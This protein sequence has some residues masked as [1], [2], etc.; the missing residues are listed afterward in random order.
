MGRGRHRQTDREVKI[1]MLHL[2][3]RC[4]D[5]KTEAANEDSAVLTQSGFEHPVGFCNHR[6]YHWNPSVLP[7]K[8]IKTGRQAEKVGSIFNVTFMSIG[9]CV[10]V[11]V[12]VVPNRC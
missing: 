4:G 2:T 3:F 10:F 12:C 1:G 6:W 9:V 8:E 7:D 5:L 11:C